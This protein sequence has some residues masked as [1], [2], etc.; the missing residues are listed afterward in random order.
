MPNTSGLVKAG[1]AM[2]AVLVAMTLYAAVHP[3][4]VVSP[5]VR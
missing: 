3:K 4:V 5:Q 2:M 1:A